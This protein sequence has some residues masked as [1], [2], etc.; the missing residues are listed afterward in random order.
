MST[1][2]ADKPHVPWAYLDLLEQRRAWPEII[3]FCDDSFRRRTAKFYFYRMC[4]AFAHAELEQSTQA[5]ESLQE[6]QG[7]ATVEYYRSRA[8]VHG[9]LGR[10][11]PMQKVAEQGLAE[12]TEPAQQRSMR[13]LKADGLHLQGNFAAAEAELRALLAEDPDDTLALNNLGYNLADQ[14]RKLPEA[15]A[16]IRRAIELSHDSQRYSGGLV[17]ENA[18]YLD[19]LGWVLFRRGEFTAARAEFERATTLA[20]GMIDATVWDHLGDCCWRLGDKPA[21]RKAWDKA[22]A[23]YKNHH[24]G[25]EGDRFTEAVRKRNRE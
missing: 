21:A 9:I 24:K 23:L 1:T 12:L 25:R 18:A 3:R 10:G 15:E 19:S 20:E 2:A 8:R 16:M 22:I 7:N 11:A 17:S 5:L 14:N 13:F 6:L 4:Q